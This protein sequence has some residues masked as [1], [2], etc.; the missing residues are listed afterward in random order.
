MSFVDDPRTRAVPPVL[1]VTLVGGLCMAAAMGIGRFAFTP[2]LPLMQQA[3]GLRLSDGAWLA[4]TNYLGY[5]LGAIFGF[6]RPPPPGRAARTGVILVAL[7]TLAMAVTHGLAAWLALRFVSGVA[8]ALVMIGVAGWALVH[9]A[10]ARRGDLGGW[11]FGCVGLS[12]AVAGV[13]VIVVGTTVA[14]P[15]PA[16]AILGLAAA[17]I[18]VVTWRPLA[19][20]P[21]AHA[22][23]A[24]DAPP[25][26]RDGWLLIVCYGVAGFGYIVPATFLPAVARALVNDPAV[27]GWVW[28]VFGVAAAIGT[29][30]V[31]TFFSHVP[32]RTVCAS[33]MLVMAVGTATPVVHMSIAT[34][35]VSAICVGGTFILVTLA[36]LQEV[37]RIAHVSPARAV[38]GM[39]ASFAL[40]QL[41]G[42]LLAQGGGTAITAMRLPSIVAT[43]ALV[44]SA[45]I[46]L[47][48]RSL[49]LREAV[50]H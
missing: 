6:V 32:P 47:R 5:L 21:L 8:S 10:T 20:G 11:V 45:T 39:T 48:S 35:I 14:D 4:M 33:G 12:I 25:I 34:L 27:F 24:V 2:L 37:R 43:I 46:L 42:P 3:Q 1:V 9:L 28:P 17:V 7:S 44:V 23:S 38:A 29:I 49:R 15:R 40:G 50:G 31:S 19:H 41:F 36:G 26:D 13:V 22:A 16:W 30:G 18:A